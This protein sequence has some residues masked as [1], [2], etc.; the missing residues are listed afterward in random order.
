MGYQTKVQSIKRKT[1][2]QF[3][4]NFPMQT[5]R[6]LDLK[7]GEHVEW[8]IEDRELLILRRLEAPPSPL[9]KKRQTR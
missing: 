8:G 5:A 3:Y 7:A 4:I 2:E 1:S 6:M 9:K